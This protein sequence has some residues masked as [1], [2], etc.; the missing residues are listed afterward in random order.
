MK[1]QN[2]RKTAAA[3]HGA[4]EF[5]MKLRFLLRVWRYFT[6]KVLL[7]FVCFIVCFL[8]LIIKSPWCGPRGSNI[9]LTKLNSKHLNRNSCPQ[10]PFCSSEVIC[11]CVEWCV[12]VCVCY[13]QKL[14]PIS[15]ISLML[16]FSWLD[17]LSFQSTQNDTRDHL[18]PSNS[19][20]ECVVLWYRNANFWFFFLQVSLHGNY[21]FINLRKITVV[22]ISWWK[23]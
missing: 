12:C 3:V 9:F 10:F 18:S 14:I 5:S 15:H 2:S 13:F 7:L 19:A 8:F 16:I 20:L 17:F 22:P 4:K 21:S 1:L 11:V 23:T 6:L